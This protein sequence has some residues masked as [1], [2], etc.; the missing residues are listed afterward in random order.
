MIRSRIARS[1]ALRPSLAARLALLALAACSPREPR[2]AEPLAQADPPPT[3]PAAPARQPM[4]VAPPAPAP[5]TPPEA[6]AAPATPATPTPAAQPA[7]V[8]LTGFELGGTLEPD[9]H[10]GDARSEF[11]P[12]ETV[13]LA[14]LLDGAP[15]AVKLEVSWLG[16]DQARVGVQ[17]SE[18]TLDGPKAVPFALASDVGLPVGEYRAEIRLDGWLASTATFRVR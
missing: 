6:P 12:A 7:D 1:S 14:L 13:R 4:P 11:T 3:Q 5:S 9:G 17:D 15:R 8:R 2:A 10:V 18:V 16:P